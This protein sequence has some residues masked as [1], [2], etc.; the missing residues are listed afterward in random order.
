MQ[1]TLLATLRAKNYGSEISAKLFSIA[2]K[3]SEMKVP[4]V[5]PM[6]TGVYKSCK[7]S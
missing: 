4:P 7:P 6:S 5:L 3:L 2:C 1:S